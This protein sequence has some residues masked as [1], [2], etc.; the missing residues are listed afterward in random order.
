MGNQQSTVPNTPTKG[1]RAQFIPAPGSPVSYGTLKLDPILDHI[2]Q[3]IDLASNTLGTTVIDCSDEFFADADNLLKPEEAISRPGVFTEN[4]AWMDGWETR[5][6]NSGYD[7]AILRLGYTGIVS[8]FDIATTHFTGN[9]APYASVEGTFTTQESPGPHCQWREVLPKAPLEANSHNYFGIHP[10]LK[11]MAY[12][13]L[14][15]KIY[16]DGGVARFRVYGNVSPTFPPPET[17][18][19]LAAIGHGGKV[20]STSNSHFSSGNNLILPGKG[21]NMGDGWETRRSRELKHNDWVILRLGCPGRLER[22]CI[23]TWHFKG[24]FPQA[25]ELY[26]CYT[27]SFDP[28]NPSEV[29]AADGGGDGK[30]TWYRILDREPLSGHEEHKFNLK[31]MTKVFTHVRMVI[32]PDG[33]ASR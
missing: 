29:K 20:V 32:Y 25:A 18:I 9:H 6:H 14:R 12:T 26:A 5:R 15:L 13:H 23:D 21:R 3:Q 27:K 33:G 2:K 16:P 28:S 1:S 31:H 22:A 4:G 24:N 7:W 8:A 11:D 19:D 17:L 10:S 30:V